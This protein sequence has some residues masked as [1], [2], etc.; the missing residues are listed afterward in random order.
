MEDRGQ[1]VE[2]GQYYTVN[3]PFNHTKVR[4]WLEKRENCRW[5]EPFAGANNIVRMVKT[6][7]PNSV[8]ECYDIEPGDKEVIQK[9]VLADFP[10]NFDVIVTNPPY[11]AK[12]SARRRGYDKAVEQMGKWEDLYLKCLEECLNNAKF[13][14]AIIPESFIVAEVLKNRLEFVVSLTEKMFDDTEHP[15]CLAVFGPEEPGEYEIY[16][17]EKLLGGS[18]KL[19][20]DP[21]NKTKAVGIKFNIPNGRIGLIAVDSTKGASIKFVKGEEIDASEIVHTS[22]HRTRI[23]APGIEKKTKKEIAEII[24][25]ANKELKAWRSRTKDVHMS[26]FMGL[27]KDGLYRRR[28]PYKMAA[29]I[30][31]KAINKHEAGRNLTK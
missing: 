31:Q 10:K 9:D 20:N 26:P 2:R 7:V 8:W 19:N 17:G 27:R 28:I 24:E 25:I 6:I 22:R 30:L 21:I 5:L 15:V 23:N 3:N 18:N 11:L 12:N 4:E 14:A 29:K 1:K 16:V 13:V